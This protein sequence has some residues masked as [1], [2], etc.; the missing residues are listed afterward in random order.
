M[1]E[2]CVCMVRSDLSGYITVRTAVY[3]SADP[4]NVTLDSFTVGVTARSFNREHVPAVSSDRPP[5]VRDSG[6]W[7][8]QEALSVNTANLGDGRPFVRKVRRNA[9]VV[10]LV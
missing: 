2:E 5:L 6:R 4:V 10:T 7:M 1:L 9:A 8:Q 3:Q